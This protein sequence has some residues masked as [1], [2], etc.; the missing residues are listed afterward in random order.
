LRPVLLNSLKQRLIKAGLPD[1]RI[2]IWSKWEKEI[3]AD[4]VGLLFAGPAFAYSMINTLLLPPQSVISYNSEDSHPSHYI[5]IFL[6]SAFVRTLIKGN[7][8]IIK[9]ADKLDNLWI[10]LY[11]NIEKIGD[12]MV[13][14]FKNDLPIIFEALIDS[15][16]DI[17]KGYSVRELI[18]YT[19]S[20]DAK[21]K[22]AIIFLI[23]GQDR[24]SYIRPRHI[25][26]ASRLALDQI[27]I[28]SNDHSNKINDLNI[29]TAELVKANTPSGLRAAVDSKKHHDFIKSLAEAL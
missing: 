10:K 7:K 24:P 16:F 20:D 19:A 3:F 5:R 14:D 21:I 4:L 13:I 18:P 22:S 17:L 15:K 9:E 11:G 28:Q 12:H 26:S 27:A 23:S 2:D 29:R 8:K 25:I 1:S 6:N